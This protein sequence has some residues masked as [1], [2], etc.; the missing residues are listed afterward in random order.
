[1]YRMS[2]IWLPRW[3]WISLRMSS[4]PAARRRSIA[5]T[6]WAAVSPNFER[7][8][9]LCAHR[10]NP[11]RGELDADTG[12]RHDAEIV[13]CLQQHIDLAQLLDDDE[14]LV[15]EPLAH[16][17]QPHE[18]LVLVPVAHDHVVGRLRERQHR[19]Q[20]RLGPALEPDRRALAPNRT[21]SS[22]TWRCWL[23]LIGY[24]VV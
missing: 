23:T 12:R 6:S 1:M 13:R 16:E 14:D 3:K 7:S 17:G 21:I 2:V 19:L 5:S 10:P 20:L 22:T 9:P 18:L 11:R 24:T 4:R 15:A 8:P